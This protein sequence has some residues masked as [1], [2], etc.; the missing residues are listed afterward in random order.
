[1]PDVIQR[2]SLCW[3]GPGPDLLLEG[4][5]VLVFED[6]NLKPLD[7]R[8]LEIPEDAHWP[9][10]QAVEDDLRR[11]GYSPMRIGRSFYYTATW[12]VTPPPDAP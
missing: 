7:I 5:W 1:M 8:R 4:S 9:P 3:L 11:M 2:A 10:V 12:V 6:V